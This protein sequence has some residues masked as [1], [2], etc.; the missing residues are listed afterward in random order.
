L[1]T[2]SNDESAMIPSLLIDDGRL[3]SVYSLV[4]LC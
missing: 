3:C 4:V 2:T 1:L